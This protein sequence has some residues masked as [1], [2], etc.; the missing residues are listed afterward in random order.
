MGAE[1]KPEVQGGPTLYSGRG[2][3]PHETRHI[4]EE[5]LATALLIPCTPILITT[6]GPEAPHFTHETTLSRVNPKS[7]SSS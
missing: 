5:L 7:R 4:M 6:L 1:E 2:C 3:G